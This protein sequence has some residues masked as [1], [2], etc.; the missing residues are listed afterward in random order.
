MRRFLW[1]PTCFG[2]TWRWLESAEIVQQIVQIDLFDGWAFFKTGEK[3]E[4]RDVGFADEPLDE[5]DTE[6]EEDTP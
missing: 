4:W 5:A 2:R 1:I 3:F 6:E